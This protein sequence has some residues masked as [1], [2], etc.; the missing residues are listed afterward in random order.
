LSPLLTQHKFFGSSNRPKFFSSLTN[1]VSG[2]TMK[3]HKYKRGKQA[4]LGFGRKDDNLRAL[5][6]SGTR[7]R[8]IPNFFKIEDNKTI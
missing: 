6:N 2:E 1:E 5:W 3:Q 4:V 8:T 7:Q